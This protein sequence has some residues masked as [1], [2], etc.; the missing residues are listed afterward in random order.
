MSVARST[1]DHRSPFT[2]GEKDEVRDGERS[3]VSGGRA[4]WRFVPAVERALEA[5]HSVAPSRVLDA[6]RAA[7]ALSVDVELTWSSGDGAAVTLS[8][9]DRASQRWVEQVLLP[10]FGPGRWRRTG[11][12]EA[13]FATAGPRAW[14]GVL[15]GSRTSA[16]SQEDPRPWCETALRGLAALPTSRRVIWRLRAAG[17]GRGGQSD[18]PLEPSPVPPGYRLRGLT[19]PERADRDRRERRRRGPIWLVQLTVPGAAGLRESADP[20]C[21][22]LSVASGRD[23]DA[24]LEFRPHREWIRARPPELVLSEAEI[25]GILPAPDTTYRARPEPRVAGLGL[26]IGPDSAGG[27]AELPCEPDQ[28]R[29]LALVG[30]TGM[31][32][33]SLLL[34]LAAQATARGSVVLFDPVGDTARRFLARLR[35]S[36]RSRVVWISP[37]RSPVAIDLLASLREGGVGS[38]ASDRSLSDLVDA[39][40]R[41]RAARYADTPFWGPRIEETVRAALA[42]AA[43]IP[44]ATLD[45]AE[46]LLTAATGRMGPVPPEAREAV[47]ALRERVRSRPEE[48]DGSR[49]LLHELTGRSALRRLVGARAPTLRVGEL[50]Q[51]DRITVISGDALAIGESAAR[52]LLAV[53]LAL[54]WSSRLRLP[55]PPKTFL[56]L[57]EVQWYAHEALSEMLRLGRR[58][59]LHVWMATQSLASLP[60]GVRE[61][62]RT[63]VADLVV[64]RG[65]PEDARDLARLTPALTVE[66]LSALPRG[67]AAVLLGKGE[68]VGFVRIPSVR[69][70]SPE[71]ARAA[72]DAAIEA[73]KRFWP[74]EASP[75]SEE[76]IPEPDGRHPEG[77]SPPAKD[78]GGQRALALVLWAGFLDSGAER[79]LRVR[80]EAL[81]EHADPAGAE[82]RALGRRL[83][84]AGLL[85]AND[86]DASGS[87]WDVAREGF[88]RILGGGVDPAELARATDSWRRMRAGAVLPP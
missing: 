38:A 56:V 51:S 53:H 18:G 50:V 24:R 70:P 77:A 12:C 1:F 63:N 10:V 75:P 86:R 9:R 25:A 15:G 88:E 61:A 74:S 71:A 68:H 83:Q 2:P 35:T 41:V 65:S 13:A 79:T 27:V 47:D 32:K 72:E 49:R 87:Y 42:A 6:L 69:P 3:D 46:R 34:H 30:E 17:T 84:E 64:F 58:T 62:V 66:S 76:T 85:V 52:Y 73:S 80:L 43:S 39:L 21:R 36:E 22:L 14:Y 44:G 81:R 8:V 54:A 31:G 29:H 26:S 33:S 28:G 82:V 78:G 59:N 45:D 16:L 5:R 55:S 7:A 40:R 37:V 57:D 60:E 11:P 23:G 4:S 19:E 20:L 67:E 48:V